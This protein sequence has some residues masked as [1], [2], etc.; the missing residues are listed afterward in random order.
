MPTVNTN[1]SSTD[2]HFEHLDDFE[3]PNPILISSNEPLHILEE[4]GFADRGENQRLMAQ[5][6]ND[7]SAVIEVLTSRNALEFDWSTTDYSI[8]RRY[9]PSKTI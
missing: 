6:H 7:L 1:Q 5:Y 2:D 4:M 3:T 9:F 8:R